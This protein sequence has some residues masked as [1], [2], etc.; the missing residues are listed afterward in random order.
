[1]LKEA[2]Q[3][4][5]GL[6]EATVQDING[7]T[8][9]DKQ[10][11]RIDHNPKAQTIEMS[12]LTSF[13]DYIKSAADEMGGKM[14]IH[15]QSATNVQL[16]S[17]LDYDRKREYLVNV[18][19]I[20]PGFTFNQFINH[21]NFCINLQSKAIDDPNTD[22]ALLLKF[23]GTVEAGS[24]A[25]YGDDG[26]SQKATVKTGIASKGEALVPSPVKLKLYRTFLEVEQPV[27]S[28]IFRM[29]QG[30]CGDIL[31]A[32]YEA[33]GGAWQITAMQ[34]IKKYLSEELKD[35]PNFVI[36]S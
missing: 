10:L 16:Y 26:V 8:Y 19:A 27:S 32:L 28:F 29:K 6:A 20:C 36:I 7:E 13:V 33:D 21:E 34:E 5:V 12:T 30:S 18:D 3:Y 24:V 4:I 2:L 23:A 1:M 31:C 17:A 22:K 14:I 25:E 11:F 35:F 9:S 15:V